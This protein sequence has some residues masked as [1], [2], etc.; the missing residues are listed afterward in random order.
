M[1][2][3]AMVAS[4]QFV[5]ILIVKIFNTRHLKFIEITKKVS[6]VTISTTFFAIAFKILLVTLFAKGCKYSKHDTFLVAF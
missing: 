3:L 5:T 2:Y 4:M 6:S 1:A